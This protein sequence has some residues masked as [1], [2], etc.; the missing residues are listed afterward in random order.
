MRRRDFFLGAA[1]A[2]VAR[3][4]AARRTSYVFDQRTGEVTFT[5]Q[6]MG[7][8]SSTAKF[9]AFTSEVVLDQQERVRASV[10]TTLQ[11]GTITSSWPAAEALMRSAAYLDVAHF[12]TMTFRGKAE[13]AG[14]EEAFRL[15]G[16]L[17]MRGITRPF[18][19]E[20]SLI[21][22]K[23]DPGV[24]LF[25]ASGRL[26]RAAYGMTAGQLMTG[27]TVSIGVQTQLVLPPAG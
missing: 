18:T 11:S 19:L 7:L 5:A 17:T 14:I 22:K 20:A 25:S 16:E 23:D 3:P 8:F 26:S 1:A 9:G 27:D 13:T 24:A 10:E 15:E 21:R 12:P 2:L 4:A 6:H